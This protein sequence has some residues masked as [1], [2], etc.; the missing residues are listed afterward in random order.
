MLRAVPATI[1]MIASTLSAFISCAFSS[2]ILRS[3][4]W[5]SFLLIFSLF[6]LP[7]PFFDAELGTDTVVR[8]HADDT[9]AHGTVIVDRNVR[10]DGCT[11]HFFSR[12][13]ELG[14]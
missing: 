1:F 14:L 10:G 9:E 11:L 6:G 7:E 3:W 12:V 8:R 4:V 2:A 13:V 5:V